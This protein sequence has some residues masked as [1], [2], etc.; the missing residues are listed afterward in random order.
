MVRTSTQ[1]RRR[2]SRSNNF[3]AI[4]MMVGVWKLDG[5]INNCSTVRKLDGRINNRSAIEMEVGVEGLAGETNNRVAMEEM[6]VGVKILAVGHKIIERLNNRLGTETDVE[7]SAVGYANV[8]IC[9]RLA[10]MEGGVEGL[11]TRC[12]QAVGQAS[13]VNDRVA[14][15][16][17]V[18]ANTKGIREGDAIERMGEGGIFERGLG[19]R[20]AKTKTIGCGVV[21]NGG[22]GGGRWQVGGCFGGY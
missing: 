5:T 22:H 20:R 6:M 12:A 9:D 17:G 14:T 7:E 3:I 16:V 21:G 10:E 4:E 2:S 18:G 1:N 11:S 8:S 13:S 15:E 19:Q